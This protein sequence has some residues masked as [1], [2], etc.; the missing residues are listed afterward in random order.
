MLCQTIIM[1][2]HPQM[3]HPDG[4]CLVFQWLC[5]YNRATPMGLFCY[6]DRHPVLQTCHPYRVLLGMV[7]HFLQRCHPY[8][9]LCLVSYYAFYNHVTLPGFYLESYCAFYNHVTLPGFYLESYCIFYKGVTL[10]GFCFWFPFA[11]FTIMS[12]LQDLSIDFQ[13]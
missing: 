6:F 11:L 4:V 5:G 3:Y 8:R 12:P 7:L 13:S 2:V 10:T 9:V 1:P